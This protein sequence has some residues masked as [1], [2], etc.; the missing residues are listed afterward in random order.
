MGKTQKQPAT[1]KR[2]RVYPE[3][4]LEWIGRAPNPKLL[5]R[6][7][8]TPHQYQRWLGA[9]K[10]V[11]ISAAQYHIIQFNYRQHLAE[12]LGQ[13]WAEF[14]VSGDKITIPGL[15]Y[16]VSPLELRGLWV[17]NHQ[18]N[19]L[20]CR[21]ELAVRDKERMAKELEEMEKH[22]RFYRDQL[23]LE[24]RFGWMLKRIVAPEED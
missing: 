4:L 8:V 9:T 14:F 23:I 10:G 12:L 7:G 16:P 3:D 15:K 1:L 22:A 13:D 17:S 19:V 18:V 2:V 24:S 20:S 21:L 6:L 5:R 11:W